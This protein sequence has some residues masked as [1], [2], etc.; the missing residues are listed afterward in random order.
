MRKSQPE[1]PSPNPFLSSQMLQ[2][3][4]T[5][6]QPGPSSVISRPRNESPTHFL[7][8]RPTSFNAVQGRLMKGKA[9]GRKARAAQSPHKPG[10]RGIRPDPAAPA[11][12][13]RIPRAGPAP[14][15]RGPAS[16]GHAPVSPTAAPVTPPP[17]PQL[18]P[19]PRN[20]RR[21]SSPI[22]FRPGGAL[23]LR[24]R[25]LPQG[26]VGL[27]VPLPRLGLFYIS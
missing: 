2:Q 27:V 15:L 18:P 23:P 8:S 22:T 24:R 1:I 10:R 12:A 26:P 5:T 11:P 20:V 13:A 17:P 16:L 6:D 3:Q 4:P 25:E 14:L 21:R 7:V 9:G 19:A